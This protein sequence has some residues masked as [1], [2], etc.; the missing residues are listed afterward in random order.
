MSDNLI[1][2]ILKL[3]EETPAAAATTPEAEIY[4]VEHAPTQEDAESG[5]GKVCSICGGMSTRA[6]YEEAV[7]SVERDRELARTPVT[8]TMPLRQWFIIDLLISKQIA[9][10]NKDL[11]EVL[12]LTMLLSDYFRAGHAGPEDVQQISEQIDKVMAP[13]AK[14]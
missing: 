6:M 3:A 2:R 14:G 12:R 1:D 7:R 11:S 9:A 4:C 8:V 10:H 13:L 5:I